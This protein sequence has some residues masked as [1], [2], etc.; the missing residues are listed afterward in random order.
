MHLLLV[1]P[2][3]A[4]YNCEKNSGENCPT[5]PEIKYFHRNKAQQFEI[6]SY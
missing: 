2:Y 3:A 6:S 5:V 4:P 1:A